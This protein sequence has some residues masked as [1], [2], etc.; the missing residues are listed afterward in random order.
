[1]QPQNN[2]RS[3]KEILGMI[4]KRNKKSK[5]PYLRRPDQIV[6][7]IVNVSKSFG[8]KV[9]MSNLPGIDN[10][11]TNFNQIVLSEPLISKY[12]CSFDLPVV[13]LSTMRETISNSLVIKKGKNQAVA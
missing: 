13:Q 2:Y 9:Q 7:K 3:Q 4:R 6:T 1:M 8:F 5:G 10:M 11:L 12:Y